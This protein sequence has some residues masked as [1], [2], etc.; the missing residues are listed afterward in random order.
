MS[1]AQEAT[2]RIARLYGALKAI[3]RSPPEDL[4]RIEQNHAARVF[5]DLE[6]RRAAQL[7]TIPGETPLAAAILHACERMRRLSSYLAD[8]RLTQDNDPAERAMRGIALGW[9]TYAYGERLS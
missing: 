9:K 6:R 2:A 4:V 8:E 5:G 7:A 1:N 3:R